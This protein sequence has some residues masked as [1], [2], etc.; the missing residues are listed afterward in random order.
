MFLRIKHVRFNQCSKSL[1]AALACQRYSQHIIV[2]QSCLCVLLVQ[3]H[4]CMLANQNLGF[5]WDTTSNPPAI[6]VLL[7]AAFTSAVSGTVHDTEWGMVGLGIIL[8]AA[9]ALIMGFVFHLVSEYWRKGEAWYLVLNQAGCLLQICSAWLI[10]NSKAEHMAAKEYSEQ[11]CSA[12]RLH[13][14]WY[15]HC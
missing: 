8:G 2:V 12:S 4:A 13:R 11:T 1:N 9:F 14:A 3:K 7:C 10:Y 6:A 15:F 5:L